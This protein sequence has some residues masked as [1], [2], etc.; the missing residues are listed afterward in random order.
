MLSFTKVFELNKFSI[1][2]EQFSGTQIPVEKLLLFKNFKISVLFLS[3]S[4]AFSDNL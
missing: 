4:K 1:K 3:F 2:Y